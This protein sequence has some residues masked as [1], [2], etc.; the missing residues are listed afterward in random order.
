MAYLPVKLHRFISAGVLRHRI[1]IQPAYLSAESFIQPGAPD[2][3]SAG[4]SQHRIFLAGVQQPW[5]FIQPA[6]STPDF[7]SAGVP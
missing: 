3:F 6:Y 2:H 7:Y 5:I 1:F 4:I